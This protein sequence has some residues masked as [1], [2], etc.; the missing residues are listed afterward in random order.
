MILVIG[1]TGRIGRHVV[2]GLV[3]KHQSVRAL[4]RHPDA[5]KRILANTAETVAGD[6]D[7][8]A[9]LDKAMEGVEAIYLASAIGDRMASQHQRVFDA[10][11][12]AGCRHVVRISTEAV[13][14]DAPFA[15]R[16]WHAKG[17]AA[18]EASGLAWTHLRPCNFMHNMLTFAPEI[19]R[20]GRFRAPFGDSSMALVDVSDIAAVAVAVL[21]EP[22]HEAKAY[23]VTG[24]DWLSFSQVAAIIGGA[25]GR[26]VRYE[27]VSMKEAR[28][29]WAE[30]GKPDWLIDDLAIMYGLLAQDKEPTTTD[31]VRRVAGKEPVRFEIFAAA[32]ADAFREGAAAA[33]A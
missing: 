3:E 2:A 10:A 15:L 23:K 33:H 14:T 7:D 28:L 6:L 25:I 9:S 21:T 5:A 13:E 8:R 12:A 32:H 31:V 30:E 19:A 16:R 20:S 26:D 27:P 22:G 4:S 11:K 1:A 17:E 29:L 18:L 24:E